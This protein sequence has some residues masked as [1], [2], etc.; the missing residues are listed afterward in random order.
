MNNRKASVLVPQ[1]RESPLETKEVRLLACAI[2]LL[3]S[4]RVGQ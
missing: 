3:R 1:G 2:K 4:P